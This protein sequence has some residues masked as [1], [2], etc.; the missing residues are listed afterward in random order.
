MTNSSTKIV[1]KRNRFRT[2][3]FDRAASVL[4][5]MTGMDGS[6]KTLLRGG[7][8]TMTFRFVGLAAGYL[9]SFLVARYEGAEAMGGFA[10]YF[11]VLSIAVVA[12]KVGMDMT[13]LRFISGLYNQG[14][15]ASARAV[16]HKALI[17]ASLACVGISV[18]LFE[19][20]GVIARN[21]FGKEEFSTYLKFAALSILPAMLIV[22]NAESLR[23]LKK[24]GA[25]AFFQMAGNWLFATGFLMIVMLFVKDAEAAIL[26]YLISLLLA[27]AVSFIAWHRLGYRNLFG[28]GQKDESPS[29]GELMA[30]SVPI[31]FSGI[32]F[33][34]LT[35]T[36]TL[37]LG[38]FTSEADVGVYSIC[39]KIVAL[40]GFSLLAVNSIAAPRFAES[41]GKG[42]M[43][44][45]QETARNSARIA[46]WSSAPI[47]LIILLFPS[48]LLAIFGGEFSLGTEA[49][50]I[51]TF[52]Q[53]VNISTGSVAYVLQMTGREKGFLWISIIA[54]GINVGL[55]LLLI[56]SYGINGAA[57]ASTT[58]LI[59]WN[60]CSVAYAKRSLNILTVYLPFLPV[61]SVAIDPEQAIDHE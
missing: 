2:A 27:C 53:L 6:S 54:A 32:A 42:D 47:F 5:A 35:M 8:T 37:M 59:F 48:F 18:L 19:S 43:V 57:A 61:N 30:V 51:L 60:L 12:S 13:L 16:Y 14:K 39:I 20:S 29:T 24:I 9:F 3:A 17:V 4:M 46:F 49:L 50:V 10:I 31:L 22:L 23:A 11:A 1:K 25:Y 40:A 38:V 44:D 36:D 28:E 34:V 45:L 55:N 21:I 56:P 58:S 26:A 7:I 33:M 15:T 52:G 41:Y